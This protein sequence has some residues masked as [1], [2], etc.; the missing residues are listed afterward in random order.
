MPKTYENQNGDDTKA[1]LHYF[2]SR[3]D[4]DYYITEKDMGSEDDDKQLQA[5]GLVKLNNNYPEQGY[6]DLEFVLSND[7]EL[8]FHFEQQTI[9]QIKKEI[10]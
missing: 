4:V 2:S 1:F 7:F 8:D 3:F 10:C 6:I 9:S 5:Y